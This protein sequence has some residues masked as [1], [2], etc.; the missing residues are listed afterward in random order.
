MKQS[1]RRA[2]RLMR[3]KAGGRDWD[4]RADFRIVPTV[5]ASDTG[6]L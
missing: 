6:E 5:F 3:F 1:V 4:Y 2:V